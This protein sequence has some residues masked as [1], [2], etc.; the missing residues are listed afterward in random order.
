MQ[1]SAK[2]EHNTVLRRK[3]ISKPVE[4]PVHRETTTRTK[5]AVL[6]KTSCHETP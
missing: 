1:H 2:T 3:E 6:P 5:W 4:L